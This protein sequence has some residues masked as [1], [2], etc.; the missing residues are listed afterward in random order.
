V[1]EYLIVDLARRI[2]LANAAL[3]PARGWWKAETLTVAVA[4]RPEDD[5]LRISYRSEKPF[6]VQSSEW[7]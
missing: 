3:L 2:A 5:S 4:Y 7:R 1:K 6:R